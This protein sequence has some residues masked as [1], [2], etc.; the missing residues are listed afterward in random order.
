MLLMTRSFL[1]STFT[2]NRII[3]GIVF[4]SRVNQLVHRSSHQRHISRKMKTILFAICAL[5][6]T[7]FDLHYCYSVFSHLSRNATFSR[8]EVLCTVLAIV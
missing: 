8:V 5:K 7:Q 1:H 4:T 3:A 2:G 6:P